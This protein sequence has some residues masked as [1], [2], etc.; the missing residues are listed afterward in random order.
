MPPLMIGASQTGTPPLKAVLEWTA[1][2]G[3]DGAPCGFAAAPAAAAAAVGSSKC[4]LAADSAR[5]AANAAA[6]AVV[7]ASGGTMKLA[8]SEACRT[9]NTP[10]SKKVNQPSTRPKLALD[11]PMVLT[12]TG[13]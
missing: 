2:R 5:S 6:A 9:T 13:H 11:D 3:T 10:T 12:R 4:P 1:V 8:K 7:A